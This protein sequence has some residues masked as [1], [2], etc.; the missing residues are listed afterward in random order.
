VPGPSDVAF[1]G[2]IPQLYDELLVPL[3]FE[4]YATE[5]AARAAALAPADVLEVAAGTGALTRALARALPAG[6]RLTATDLNQPMLDR[7]AAVAA[8]RPVAWRRADALALPFAEASFD[9]V[10]CAFGAM[11][12]P[13]RPRA[14]AEARRVLRP[15]GALLVATWDRL[16]TCELE[17]AVTDALAEVFPADPPRFLARTPHGYFDPAAIT[18]DLAAAGFPARAEVEVLPARCP[19]VSPLAAA[20][21]LCQG[22][23]LRNEI[24]ARGAPGLDAATR[25][26][27]AALARRYGPDPFETRMQALLCAVRA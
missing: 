16:E 12:F 15:G 5:L 25:A 19:A 11:F 26:C 14:F 8:A 21:A 17:A 23:P 7:A 1:A 24:E 4:P 13:D 6:A 3:L 2:S 18:T 9:L 27:A 20:T 22:T 10:A